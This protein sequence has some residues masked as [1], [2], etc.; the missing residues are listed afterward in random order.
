MGLER[1]LR[2]YVTSTDLDGLE[3][4]LRLHRAFERQTRVLTK[5]RLARLEADLARVALLLR[6]LADLSLA[7]GLVTREEL[8]QHMLAAD[9]ADGAQDERLDPRAVMPGA[10]KPTGLP[11]VPPPVG[12]TRPRKRRK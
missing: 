3:A 5:T 6:T 10:S 11:N 12:R 7:K 2:R 1:F 4:R 8:A 9:L